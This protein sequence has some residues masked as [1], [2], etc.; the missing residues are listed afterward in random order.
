MY[1]HLRKNERT[2]EHTVKMEVSLKPNPNQV[3]YYTISLNY[4]YVFS[5]IQLVRSSQC[6]SPFETLREEEGK[7]Y[8]SRF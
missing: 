8:G 3:D 7:S 2:R 1:N 4:R 6:I 5:L